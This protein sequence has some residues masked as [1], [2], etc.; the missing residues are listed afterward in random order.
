[1]KSVIYQVEDK[2]F[3]E[4]VKS[5]KSYSEIL[6][7]CGLPSRGAN[8]KTI[9]RR[10]QSLNVD[11]SHLKSNLGRTFVHRQWSLEDANREVF[12]IDSDTKP[13]TTKTLILRF[14]L[15]KYKCECGITDSW[16]GKSIT[17]QLEHKN[18]NHSDNRIENLMFL[19]PNCHSQT[20][21]YAGKSSHKNLDKKYLEKYDNKEFRKDC[22]ILVCKD[23]KEKYGIS[24]HIL[25]RLCK[26]MNME[27][28][29]QKRHD[30]VKWNKQ[31]LGELEVDVKKTSLRQLSK[32]YGVSANR[33]KEVCWSNQIPI[34]KVKCC[35]LI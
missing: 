24:Q 9:I 3:I 35:P 28:P 32:K 30:K 25:R 2:E 34:P 20:E 10:I 12:V 26:I 17:L 31:I 11:Y 23:I 14:G 33:L 19:C 18:G 22:H 4:I 29:K 6:G 1:M 16:R 7:K 8:R 5:S 15:L 27:F 21:T 13:T